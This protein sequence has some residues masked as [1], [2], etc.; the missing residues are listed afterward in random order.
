MKSGK[1]YG[2]FITQYNE[3]ARTRATQRRTADHE[4]D[5]SGWNVT[6][7]MDAAD[8]ARGNCPVCGRRLTRDAVVAPFGGTNDLVHRPSPT[9]RLAVHRTCISGS[10]ALAQRIDALEFDRN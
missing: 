8:V 5:W 4:E 1:T 10:Y 6:A 9:A 2:V 7:P 3:S